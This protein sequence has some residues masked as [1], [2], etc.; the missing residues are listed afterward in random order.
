MAANQVDGP[1]F[2]MERDPRR[3]ISLWVD[4]KILLPTVYTLGG[5]RHV[6]RGW[7]LPGMTDGSQGA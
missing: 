4:I 7:I 3:H 6:P 1:Q 5:Q 2:K